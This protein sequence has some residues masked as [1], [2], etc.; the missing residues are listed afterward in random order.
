VEGVSAVVHLAAVLRT[1]N[2]DDIWGADQDGTKNVIAGM[3]PH[4][5]QIRFVIAALDWSTTRTHP[6][7]A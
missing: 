7:P 2:E 1:Q 6:I 5:P 4:P 3:K